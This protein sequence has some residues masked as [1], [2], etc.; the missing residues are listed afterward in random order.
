MRLFAIASALLLAALTSVAAPCSVQA[1]DG[2][3]R[4]GSR[5]QAGFSLSI[6]SPHYD[7]HHYRKRYYDPGYNRLTPRWYWVEVPVYRLLRYWDGHCWRT[8][9]AVS[10]YCL[11]R[12]LV[13]WCPEHG[14]L[15]Y[16]HE[17]RFYRYRR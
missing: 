16:Y 14:C 13:R 2:S 4:V 3:I 9:T 15:G 10:G 1:A 7:S 8:H 5:R 11:V 12:V 17:G 6:G